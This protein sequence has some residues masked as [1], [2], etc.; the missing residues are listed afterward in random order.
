MNSDEKISI[1]ASCV[2]VVQKIIQI[3]LFQFQFERDWNLFHYQV[4]YNA[5]K[6]VR[7]VFILSV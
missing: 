3:D 1:C 5:Q 2:G 7:A 4:D 6:N